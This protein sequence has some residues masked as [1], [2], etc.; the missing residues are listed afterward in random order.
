M[1][2]FTLTSSLLGCTQ[3]GPCPSESTPVRGEDKLCPEPWPRATP[4][5]SCCLSHHIPNTTPA[6]GTLPP[7]GQQLPRCRVTTCCQLMGPAL[8]KV[9][10]EGVAE[11]PA[12]R[13]VVTCLCPG[14]AVSHLRWAL[15]PGPAKGSLSHSPPPRPPTRSSQPRFLA[16]SQCLGP[17]WSRVQLHC[18]GEVGVVVVFALCPLTPQEGPS[19]GRWE[20]VQSA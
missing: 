3:S 11:L 20:G 17:Y 5:A 4:R 7:V 2:I 14:G 12:N 16:G 18:G 6:R 9:P 8:R 13:P 15:G 19:E 1:T 10:L